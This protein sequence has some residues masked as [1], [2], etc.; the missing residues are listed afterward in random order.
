MPQSR[1]SNFRCLLYVNQLFFTAYFVLKSIVLCI[2]VGIRLRINAWPKHRWTPWKWTHRFSSSG[3]E[4]S[5]SWVRV[6]FVNWLKVNSN[7]TLVSQL[8]NSTPL[9]KT[10]GPWVACE[11][12]RFFRLR[13]QRPEISL[14]FAGYSLRYGEG[15]STKRSLLFSEK[16]KDSHVYYVFVL[17]YI[18]AQCKWQEQKTSAVGIRGIDTL[19]DR[20]LTRG[21]TISRY[22]NR[23]VQRYFSKV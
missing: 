23:L 2:R 5:L 15:L 7:S 16:C 4:T 3:R 20:G 12:I 17:I 13:K 14:R 22:C 19:G 1:Q 11:S 21:M 6:K 18:L 8:S 10:V 9:V